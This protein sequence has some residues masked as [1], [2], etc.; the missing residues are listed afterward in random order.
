MK[1]QN[2]FQCWHNYRIQTILNQQKSNIVLT[3]KQHKLIKIGLKMLNVQWLQ[4]WLNNL[5][6][7]QKHFKSR[8]N[9]VNFLTVGF[10]KKW[11]EVNDKSEEINCFGNM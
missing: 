4:D 6:L 1:Q 5:S 11:L 9:L 8:L 3:E 7:Y 10:E 2:T